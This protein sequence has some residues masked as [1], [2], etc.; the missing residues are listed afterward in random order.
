MTLPDLE[1]DGIGFIAYYNISNNVTEVV[2][3]DA[4]PAMETFTEYENGV[5]GTIHIDVG[6]NALVNCRVKDDGWMAVWLDAGQELGTN[7]PG[8]ANVRGQ[9]D[10][11]KG[12]EDDPV[13]DN[14]LHG[15]LN[16]LANSMDGSV[17]VNAADASYYNFQTPNATGFSLASSDY[18]GLT[19]E[20][21]VGTTLHL[22]LLTGGG[23]NSVTW[24]SGTNNEIKVSNGGIGV[25]NTLDHGLTAGQPHAVSLGQSSHANL[26]TVWS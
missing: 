3:T 19:I 23:Y 14:S 4:E 25:I 10:Y 2:P 18:S 26:L 9:H 12:W 22:G 16:S 17:S 1:P 5:D 15:A 21:T 20:P 8:G 11:L 6:G 24:K 7:L 13:E